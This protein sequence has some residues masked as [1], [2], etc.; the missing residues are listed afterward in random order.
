VDMAELFK[1]AGLMSQADVDKCRAEKREAVRKQEEHYEKKALQQAGL[2]LPPQAANLYPTDKQVQ[3]F[4]TVYCHEMRKNPDIGQAAAVAVMVAED[5]PM[6]VTAVGLTACAYRAKLNKIMEN[7]NEGFKLL[8]GTV[9]DN[10]RV[11][12]LLRADNQRIVSKK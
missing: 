1:D 5:R 9:F 3:T 6:E 12:E 2:I 4:A 7:P 10:S 8:L 11:E